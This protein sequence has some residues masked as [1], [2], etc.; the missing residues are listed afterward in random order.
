MGADEGGWEAGI[1]RLYEAVGR[2][3]ELAQAL[4]ALRPA[5]DAKSVSYLTIADPREPRSAFIGAMGITN[6][7]LVEYHSHFSPYDEW[8]KAVWVRNGYVVGATYRGSELASPQALRGSYFGREFLAKHAVA[9]ILSCVVEAPGENGP[10]TVLTFHRGPDQ[11]LFDEAAVPRLA[12]LVPHLRRVLRLH[13]RLAPQLAIG[14][15]LGE[16]FRGA[17]VP[18]LFVGRDGTVIEHNPAAQA[19]FDA[20]PPL[21][22]RRAGRLVVATA[23]G[24]VELA[25]RLAAL[26]DGPAPAFSVDLVDGQGTTATLELRRV[27]GAATD[28]LAQHHAVAVCALRRP[29]QGGSG[30]LW[31][32]FRLTPMEARVAEGL[33][34]G[35]APDAVAAVLDVRLSTVRTHVRSLFAKTGAK[36]LAELVAILHGR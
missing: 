19:V 2:E 14:A 22:K 26:E 30:A 5:F 31:R 20:A 6:D 10:A 1:E 24:W 33:A 17:D 25:A 4:G 3:D 12:A 35:Q 18:L 36:R 23:E 16:L 29:A 34:A 15:T 7:A 32:R 27:H 8:A 28:R 11:P 13:R 21:L 9:D